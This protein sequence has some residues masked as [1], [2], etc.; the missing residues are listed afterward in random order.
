MKKLFNILVFSVLL[1]GCA[2]LVSIPNVVVTIPPEALAA[3]ASF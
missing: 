1:A 3:V 2:P